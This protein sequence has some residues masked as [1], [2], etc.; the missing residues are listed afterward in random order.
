MAEP[1][2][3]AAPAPGAHIAV[4]LLFLIGLVN[5]ID[6]SAMSVLQVPLKAELRLSDE[7]M[8]LLM[9]FAFFIPYTA[10][11]I[12]MARLADRGNRKLILIA[13]L[14]L[15]SAMTCAVGVAGS[16]LVLLLLRA[17]V[18]IGEACCLPTS[19]SLIA[20][21]Y[22]KRYH[23]TAIAMLGATFPLG[24]MMGLVL[25]GQLEF[26]LG[27]RGA[28]L[29]IGVLGICLAP[30]LMVAMK[31]PV[32]KRGEDGAAPRSPK[33]VEALG[34]MWRRKAF[35]FCILGLGTQSIASI[36][37][38]TWAVPFYTRSFDLDLAQA[39]LLVGFGMSLAG[40]AGTLGGGLVGD[41]IAKHHP[42]RLMLMCALAA[43]LATPVA[44][45]QLL[46]GN[47]T[48]SIGVALVS[49]V[50]VSAYLAPCN[51]YIQRLAAPGTR[52]LSAAAGVTVAAVIGGG[53]APWGVGRL[54][55]HLGAVTGSA[56]TGLRYAVAFSILSCVLAAVCFWLSSRALE[57]A[58]KPSGRMA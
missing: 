44:L 45:L 37:L 1:D 27:W 49:S 10:L 19:Y 53:L 4:A 3:G 50:F 16:F 57:N 18:A 40:A 51:A 43:I 2:G 13:A 20:D 29:A 41:R 52:A 21:Y 31:E 15:W 47:L 28:F 32:R 54:S 11:S 8:G 24:S 36:S 14:L 9:G 55:D 33:L 38:L 46:T 30:L 56:A 5:Y 58:D 42:G 39:S 25:G 23:G 12:P 34:G 35:R 26:A 7:Q 48:V 17:G 6:R 22:P